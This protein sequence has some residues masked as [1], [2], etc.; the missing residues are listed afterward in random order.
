[1]ESYHGLVVTVQDAILLVEATRKHEIPLITRRLTDFERATLIKNGAVFIWNESRSN[2][3]RWT[4][5]KNWSASRVNGVFLTYK[6]MENVRARERNISYKNKGLVKQSFSIVLKDGE[7][8]HV[9]SYITNDYSSQEKLNRPTSDPAL[10]YITVDKTLYPPSIV[11]DYFP[12]TENEKPKRSSLKRSR[13]ELEVEETVIKRKRSKSLPLYEKQILKPR[14]KSLPGVPTSPL[15]SLIRSPTYTYYSS[16]RGKPVSPRY[17]TLPA[18]PRPSIYLPPI[19]AP[20]KCMY[21]PTRPVILPTSTSLM[22][23]S[24]VPEHRS[25][26]V[27]ATAIPEDTKTLSSLD[28]RFM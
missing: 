5:G 17:Q 16:G 20:M 21:P 14:T 18:L 26:V 28:H 1:M 15:S 7:K 3:K 9:V 27:Y 24:G 25:A 6:E 2:M 4:D 13:K 10:K 11:G 22:I 19:V 23:E 12:E 8:M